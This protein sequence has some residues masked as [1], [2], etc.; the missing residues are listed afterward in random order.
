MNNEKLTQ[1][2]N[3]S[4][5]PLQI[6][7]ENLIK[8]THGDHGWSILS[9]EHSW[10]N[11]DNG[12]SGF[13]DL[14]LED[15]S[16]TSILIVECKR[17]IDS[18][19]LFLNPAKFIKNRLHVKAWVTKKSGSKVQYFGWK[20]LTSS[21]DTPESAFCVVAGQDA[22]SKP[23]LERIAHNVVES[24]VG[25]ANEEHLN[26]VDKFD[27]LR[28]YFNVII[29]T[30]KLKVCSFDPNMVSMENGKLDNTEITEVPFLRFRKQLSTRT[31]K[32][33]SLITDGFYSLIRE[34]ENTVFVINA[35]HFL[36]FLAI[37]EVNNSSLRDLH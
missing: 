1:I 22:K 31:L 26:V 7:I 23:M 25:F 27:S 9:S 19:W 17:V 33:G 11:L 37:F 5:F 13:I 12:N 20:D 18:N 36:S 32:N 15:R 30:A 8:G 34:K 24:T 16:K 14:V 4:G 28:M 6:G 35:E 3:S 21:P 29:T 2:I 10:E